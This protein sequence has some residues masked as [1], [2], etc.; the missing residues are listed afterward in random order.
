MQVNYLFNQHDPSYKAVCALITKEIV[1]T[2]KLP[3]LVGLGDLIL[4]LPF[5]PVT[6]WFCYSLKQSLE[7]Y[8]L[9]DDPMFASLAAACLPMIAYAFLVSTYSLIVRPKCIDRIYSKLFEAMNVLIEGRNTITLQS[10]G[11]LHISE[12]GQTQTLIRYPAITRLSNLH[13]HLVIRIGPIYL[14]AVPHS[15]FA[16]NEEYR[17]FTELLQ[18]HTGLSVEN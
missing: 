8:G 5:F 17:R 14:Y 15:A 13:R 10:D 12:N 11:L 18:K 2:S 1:K 6:A 7:A 9:T 3:N 4:L 16:N